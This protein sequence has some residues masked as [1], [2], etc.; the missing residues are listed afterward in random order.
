MIDIQHEA[1]RTFEKY[2][3]AGPVGFVKRPPDGS[4][5]C[6]KI[7]GYPAQGIQCFGAIDF[8]R[9]ETAQK[10]VVMGQQV[11]DAF[12]QCIGIRQIADAYGPAR[13]LVFIGR[14]DPTPGGAD[15]AGALRRFPRPVERTMQGQNQ[16]R[17]LCYAQCLR[18]HFDALPADRFD[19]LHQRPGVDHHAIAD[20]R[21]FSP[22]HTG[23]QQAELVYL[24]VD[25]KRVTG[26]VAALKTDHHIGA[27]RKPVDDF[28]FAFIPPLGAY[29]CN[30]RHR[31]FSCSSGFAAPETQI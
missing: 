10:R 31:V 28:T 26:I 9:S 16:R 27:F 11:F 22:H 14:P 3:P 4:G 2:P 6:Q 15:F 23:G 21:Q 7:F 30:I 1:L 12:G 25:D 8:R 17:V 20:N 13:N 29:Y 19:F 5:I 18:R 24:A